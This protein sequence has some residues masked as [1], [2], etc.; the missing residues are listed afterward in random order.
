GRRPDRP[1]PSRHPDQ[2]FGTGPDDAVS[3]LFDLPFEEPEPAPTAGTAPEP[4][5]DAQL[6]TSSARTAE[7]APPATPAVR[8]ILT[9]SELTGRVRTTL[10]GQ[11][12]EVWVEGELS[13]C[14]VWNTGHM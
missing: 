4:A 3:T 8:R 1:R 5:A 11:F 9:V 10:E 2:L 7:P 12:F 14:R 13:N 6:P